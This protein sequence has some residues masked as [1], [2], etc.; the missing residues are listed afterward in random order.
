MGVV[1]LP[2]RRPPNQQV[3]RIYQAVGN[4]RVIASGERTLPYGSRIDSVEERLSKQDRYDNL[5][6]AERELRADLVALRREVALVKTELARVAKPPGLRM[7]AFAFV[8]LTVVGCGGSRGL[9]RLAPSPRQ[10]SQSY[11][12]GSPVG[13]GLL[14]MGGYLIWAVGRLI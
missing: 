10:P 14:V 6:E 12:A 8:Y 3:H 9:S 4:A 13:S 11:S 2:T 1:C 5:I 7:A